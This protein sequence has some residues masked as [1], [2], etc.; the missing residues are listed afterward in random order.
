MQA[1]ARTPLTPS[2]KQN[3]TGIFLPSLSQVF[4]EPDGELQQRAAEGGGIHHCRRS[5]PVMDAAVY[6]SLQVI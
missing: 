5:R 6:P 3:K 1:R 4:P 2:I